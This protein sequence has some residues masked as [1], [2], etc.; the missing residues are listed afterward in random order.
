ME[1]LRLSENGKTALKNTKEAVKEQMNAYVGVMESLA[2]L[3]IKLKYQK[4]QR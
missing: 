3:L 4:K 1:S 2:R